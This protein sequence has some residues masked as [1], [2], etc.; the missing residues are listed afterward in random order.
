MTFPNHK[1]GTRL[2]FA[3]V[4]IAFLALA[5]F[6]FT[7]RPI[8][9]DAFRE[10]RVKLFVEQYTRA[11]AESVSHHLVQYH[12]R[13]EAVASRLSR[14][15][16]RDQNIRLLDAFVQEPVSGLLD[17]GVFDLL[18]VVGP[19]GT[20]HYVNSLDRMGQP[21]D[22]AALLGRHISEF[23]EEE[24]AFLG[25][26]GGG[27]KQDWYRSKMVAGLRPARAR[28]P[29]AG[30]PA[31][32]HAHPADAARE[33]AIAFAEPIS[34]SKQ[35]VV[36]VVNWESVQT[37]LDM[38]EEP[39]ARAGFPSAYAFMFARDADKIIAHK[40]RQ[41]GGVNNYGV[42][43]ISNLGLGDLSLAVKEGRLS[44]RYEYPAGSPKISGLS[45]VDDADFGWTV[46]LGINDA[47]IIA[48]VQRLTIRLLILGGAVFALAWLLSHYLSNR[49]TFDLRELTRSVLQVAEG[50]AGVQV[51][52]RSRDEV[53]QL[54]AAFNT[55]AG[56]LQDRDDLIR[57]QQQR[58]YERMRLDQELRIASEVQQ[59]LLPQFRPPLTTLD[60]AGI[61]Q[62][63]RVVSGDFF[64]FLALAP[65]KLGLLVADVSGKGLSAA[66]LMSALHACIR[67]HAPLLG[68]RCGE[69]MA[70]ANSLLFEST[71]P[72]RFA[73]AFYAVYDD[74]ARRLSYVNAG[75]HPPLIVRGGDR[76]HVVAMAS[77]AS[78]AASGAERGSS[79]GAAAC[80][81]AAAPP[82]S[83]E[84]LELGTQPLGLFQTL[85]SAE[86]QMQL[87]PGDC[88]LIFS[89]G[90]LEA[91]NEHDE[92]FGQERMVDVAR[93]NSAA[94]AM[95]MRDAVLA[96]VLEHSA[97]R[98][99]TDDRTLLVA[100]V[101]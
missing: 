83:W 80:V 3:L 97:G 93:R 88:L 38:Q 23:R 36:A 13:V 52:V 94:S 60:Y 68:D 59:R 48:P 30:Q 96:A 95:E 46:G 42:R 82:P 8:I 24:Q 74:S 70:V 6:A 72:E 55:M 76:P 75:H 89:D 16:P 44:H 15:A 54:A 90:I 35:V 47:D 39:L 12:D 33:Y 92:E 51:S 5:A 41:R 91:V 4:G 73:T 18:A 56:A 61:C 101:L 66:L 37:I 43:L 49:I 34:G 11:L 86:S 99:A 1:L 58:L 84:R 40:Y 31:L 77:A 65:G 98:A 10:D 29:A 79:T 53:G 87:A 69:V 67:S 19:D 27:G 26:L 21:V 62:P 20:I 25:A 17:H 7:A 64:D 71:D 28:P 63:A 32:A 14:P 100:R 2:R 57:A 81:S 85:A 45:H 22:A 50:R 9:R 78:A